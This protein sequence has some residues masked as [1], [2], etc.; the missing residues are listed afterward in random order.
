MST[1]Q[2]ARQHGLKDKVYGVE[3]THRE[4]PNGGK[5]SNPKVDENAVIAENEERKAQAAKEI[6][7]YEADEKKRQEKENKKNQK[8]ALEENNE[9][10]NDKDK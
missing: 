3:T 6:E 2:N 10:E 5:P 8:V 7:K 9:D 4:V 1:L